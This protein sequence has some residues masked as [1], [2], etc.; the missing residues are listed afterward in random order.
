MF[1][2]E[3]KKV[4]AAGINEKLHVF[5]ALNFASNKVAYD[6]FY[7]KTQWQMETF[8][9]KLFTEVY[10]KDYLVLVLDSVS[11]HKTLLIQNLLLDYA[12]RVFVVWLP[13]YCPKLN[14]IERF[15]EH[16]KQIAFD[17][18]YWGD[19]LSLEQ[20]AHEFFKEHNENPFSDL[21]ISFR[22][23]KDL[24]GLENGLK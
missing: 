1:K 8:L 16:M 7:A 10:Q 18:Y 23:S 3:Q 11:Y 5:G 4:P 14:L 12:D 20:A 17:S 15:W 2:G 6:I 13:K 19:A 22:L 21:A 9:L 24:S